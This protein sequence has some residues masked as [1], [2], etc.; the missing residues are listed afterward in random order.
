MAARQSGFKNQRSKTQ[1]GKMVTLNI[2]ES[3]NNDKSNVKSKVKI[4]NSSQ[5]PKLTGF[6]RESH[7]SG[8]ICSNS[9]QDLRDISIER[10]VDSDIDLEAPV[11]NEGTSWA[12]DAAGAGVEMGNGEVASVSNGQGSSGKTWAQMVVADRERFLLKN[13]NSVNSANT[14]VGTNVNT[15]MNNTGVSENPQLQLGLTEAV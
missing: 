3:V 1:V 15:D 12:D 4:I 11:T 13:T 10:E 5:Q 9:L 6:L 7:P 8:K 14:S 2:T